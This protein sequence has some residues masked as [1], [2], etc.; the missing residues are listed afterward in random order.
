MNPNLL[1]K[2]ITGDATSE[3]KEEIVRWL[4]ADKKNQKEFLA[5]R[6][7]YDISLWQ[8]VSSSVDTPKGQ[9]RSLYAALREITK[10]AAIFLI[11]FV[12]IY[13]LLENKN[14][15]QDIA[16][17]TIFVP[18]GQRAELTL[19]DGTRVWL[20]AKTTFTF[21]NHFTNKNR[22]VILDGEGY[23]KVTKNTKKPFTVH[24]RQYDITVLGTEFNVMA[25][26]GTPTFETALIKGAVEVSSAA[27]G[28]KISLKPHTRAYRENGILKKDRIGNTDHFLW[29]EGII[30]FDNEPV[31]KMMEKLQLYYDVTIRVENKDLFKNSYSGKFRIK[32][33]VEHVLKVLQLNNKF[34]YEKNDDLNLITI[35]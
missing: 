4:E 24:T 19:A 33:G 3:E 29:R 2:Y 13:L 8:E 26:S 22:K 20:N 7:I 10:V 11:A 15:S 35:K 14:E 17:Q 9:K 5:L 6:K 32:D 18:A 1:Q 25:Y 31:E 23:F 21:P 34:L 28:Q 12:S 16:M 30:S 27:G